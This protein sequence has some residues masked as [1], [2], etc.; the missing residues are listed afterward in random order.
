MLVAVSFLPL[1]QLPGPLPARRG[2]GFWPRDASAQVRPG[3]DLIGVQSGATCWDR[4][5]WLGS[6]TFDSRNPGR[7]L[8]ALSLQPVFLHFPNIAQTAGIVVTSPTRVRVA[9]TAFRCSALSWS[10]KRRAIPAP[11]IARVTMMKA[12]SGRVS[13]MSFTIGDSLFLEDKQGEGCRPVAQSFPEK[14][15]R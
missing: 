8:G 3:A 7:F 9:P 6:D 14:L 11:I 1:N 10:A 4:S 2:L 12:S 15:R 13:W 5:S